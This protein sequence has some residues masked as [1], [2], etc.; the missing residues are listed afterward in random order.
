MEVIG[1][2]M[3]NLESEPSTSN[4]LPLAPSKSELKFHSLGSER[5]AGWK[6]MPLL[7]KRTDY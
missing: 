3:Y 1:K 5:I 4:S 7:C 2:L 6:Y